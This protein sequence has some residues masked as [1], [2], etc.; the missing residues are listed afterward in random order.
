VSG[1]VDLQAEY[2]KA[3]SLP[4]PDPAVVD[5]V[6]QTAALDRAHELR[7]FEIENYW[8]RATYF[9]AFQLA[10]FTLFGL[11]WQ[12]FAERKLERAALLV[13]TTLG[14]ITA[15][16]GWLTAKGSK[17]WQE[18][19]EGHVDLL[20]QAREGR[21]TQVIINRRGQQ[22]SVSRVNEAL[23]LLLMCGWI[24]CFT[25]VEFPTLEGWLNKAPGGL[26]TT[27][28]LVLM[29]VIAIQSRMALRGWAIEQGDSGWVRVERGSLRLIVERLRR[30]LKID[31]LKTQ[32]ML[33]DP[34]HGKATTPDGSSPAP[35]EA[36]P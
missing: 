13:P 22:Y 20:E 19:W 21:L 30:L 36:T 18:N 34:A 8:K 2:L 28:L 33:R 35:S 15:Q 3:L 16:V 31:P 27:G 26:R 14:A 11:L 29:L 5:R 4:M 23:M 9:W 12:M 32:I 7:K 17:F 25:I 24:A 10:A 1:G 6:A